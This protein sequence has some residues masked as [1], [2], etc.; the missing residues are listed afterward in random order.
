MA[1]VDLHCHTLASDGSLSP[2]DLVKRAHAQGVRCLA[3]TDHDT[4]SGLAEARTTAES[5]AM[6]FIN[7]IELSSQWRGMGIHIVG[8]NFDPEHPVMK[9]AIER[10]YTARV[11]RAEQIGQRLEKLKLVDVY[12]IAQDIAGRPDV[13]RPHL[14]QAMLQL[15]YVSSHPEAFDRF[16]GAGKPGDIKTLWPDVAEVVEWINTAGGVAVIAHPGKYNMTWAKLRA[17][18]EY[19]VEAGGQAIEVSYGGEN[20]DRLAELNRLAQRYA[21]QVSVGSDFHNPKHHWTELGKYPSIRGDYQPV[22]GEW[23]L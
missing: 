18:I 7:G 12:K 21:L 5:F 22:W 4:C 19:F 17:L 3:V 8:L 10:Q 1:A 2:S 16:L 9:A 20:P 15:G 14:A 11:S 13:G 6:Q 23:L